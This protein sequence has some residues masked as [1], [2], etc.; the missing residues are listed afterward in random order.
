REYA[1]IDPGST[2]SYISPYFAIFL[3]QRVESL[4][5]PY[6][7]MTPVEGALEVDKVYETA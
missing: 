3:E 5:V 4:I 7:V 2:Y 6:M 1:L